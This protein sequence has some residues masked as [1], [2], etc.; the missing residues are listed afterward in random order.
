M[1]PR[2]ALYQILNHKVIN[3]LDLD[4]KTI[5]GNIEVNSI[6]K[7]IKEAINQ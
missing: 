6:F 7:E 3:T 2:L 1:T 5:L 4:S